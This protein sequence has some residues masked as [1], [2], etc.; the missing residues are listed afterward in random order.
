MA[1]SIENIN[2]NNSAT[3]YNRI[4]ISIADSKIYKLAK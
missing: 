4:G 1:N 3:F 2:P